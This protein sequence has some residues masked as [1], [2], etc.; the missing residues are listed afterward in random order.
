MGRKSDSSSA[1]ASVPINPRRIV[2]GLEPLHSR[3]MA[4]LARIR[5]TAEFGPKPSC[6]RRDSFYGGD[7]GL[8]ATQAHAHGPARCP[9]QSQPFSEKEPKPGSRPD[10]LP[11]PS[12]PSHRWNTVRGVPGRRARPAL[13]SEAADTVS[14]STRS[15]ANATI[16]CRAKR[17]GMA[18]VEAA[19][20]CARATMCQKAD[21]VPFG[22]GLGSPPRFAGTSAAPQASAVDLPV[23]RRNVYRLA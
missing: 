23:E 6:L 14:D 10:A 19:V 4:E 1:A 9:A 16:G 15:S 13:C 12:S 2:C 21:V 20:A 22:R 11:L 8:C 3:T 17:L 7:R 18:P 5:P